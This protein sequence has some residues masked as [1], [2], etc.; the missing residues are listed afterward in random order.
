MEDFLENQKREYEKVQQ[1]KIQKKRDEESLVLIVPHLKYFLS[2]CK[3]A[4]FY[5]SNK[6]KYD[7]MDVMIGHLIYDDRILFFNERFSILR[8]IKEEILGGWGPNKAI[9]TPNHDF[10]ITYKNGS[11]WISDTVPFQLEEW[12]KASKKDLGLL[13][14]FLYYGDF[15]Q[16]KEFGKN[17]SAAYKKYK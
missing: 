11:F 6:G 12:N 15:S 14:S 2:L 17:I 3:E 1:G 4:N 9:D 13:I 16:I 7:K 10:T 8:V 5:E